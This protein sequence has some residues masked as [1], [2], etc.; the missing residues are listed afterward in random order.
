MT[1]DAAVLAVIGALMLGYYWARWR[2]AENTNRVAKAAVDT[3]GKQA[4]RA[5]GVMVLVGFFVFVLIDL[6][7]RGSGRR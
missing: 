5:R 3:A 4:W 2:R 1:R 6:W 7:I